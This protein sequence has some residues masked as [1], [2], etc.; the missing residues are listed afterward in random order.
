VYAIVYG[1]GIVFVDDQEVPV[2]PGQFIAVTPD[3]ARQVRAGDG[4]LV[5][6]AICAAPS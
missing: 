4:G 1:T 5:F 3:S 2:R 6:I